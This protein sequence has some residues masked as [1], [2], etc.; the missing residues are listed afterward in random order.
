MAVAMVKP[1]ALSNRV[2][3]LMLNNGRSRMRT[4]QDRVS[5]CEGFRKIEGTQAGR[6]EGLIARAILAWFPRLVADTM[7]L[8]IAA[9]AAVSTL[10]G[11]IRSWWCK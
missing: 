7:V 2:E 5:R 10:P 6:R 1:S 11:L 8:M 4:E 9:R 3:N